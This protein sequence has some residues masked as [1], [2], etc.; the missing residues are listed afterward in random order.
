LAEI[1]ESEKRKRQKTGNNPLLSTLASF[2][3]IIPDTISKR[4]SGST[5]E[6]TNSDLYAS[7]KIALNPHIEDTDTLWRVPLN[8]MRDNEITFKSFPNEDNS[9]Y[10]FQVND[11]EED[12]KPTEDKM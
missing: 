6:G 9:T 7:K 4:L 2:S 3:L 11:P 12:S 8:S 10:R 1:E 5:D